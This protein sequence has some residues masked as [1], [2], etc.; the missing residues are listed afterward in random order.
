M[1]PELIITFGSTRDAIMGERLLLDSG[2]EVRV[3]PMPA[4][5]GPVCGIALRLGQ[6][7]IERAQ[8]LLGGTLR[9][10]YCRAAESERVFAPWNP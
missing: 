9:G 2:V 8:A 4:Q 10:I 5:L 1:E 6:Q 7:D 3:M